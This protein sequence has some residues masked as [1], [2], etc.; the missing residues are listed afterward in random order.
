MSEVSEAPQPSTVEL[1][2]QLERL[3]TEAVLVRLKPRQVEAEDGS[4]YTIYTF[5]NKNGK[6]VEV[7]FYSPNELPLV[8]SEVKGKFA[9]I[10]GDDPR[11]RTNEEWEDFSLKII[12]ASANAESAQSNYAEQVKEVVTSGKGI[13]LVEAGPEFLLET[14]EELGVELSK[15]LQE[16]LSKLREKGLTDAGLEV[17]DSVL[18]GNLINDEEGFNTEHQHEGEALFLLSLMGDEK[19]QQLLNKKKGAL[20]KV[21]EKREAGEKARFAKLR[22]ENEKTGQEA[23][24]LKELVAVHATR[25]LP[26]RGA[27]Y[28]EILTTFEGSGWQIPRDT[29]HF[30]LNHEVA[31]HMY[32]SWEGVPYVVI[33]PLEKMIKVNGKPTVLNTVD[34]F[35]EVGPGK[36]LVL[37]ENTAMVRPGDLSEGEILRGVNSNEVLYKASKLKPEDI[38]TL[39]KELSKRARDRLNSNIVGIVVESFSECPYGDQIGLS[40]EQMKSLVEVTGF[41]ENRLNVLADLQERPVKEVVSNILKMAEV[42]VADEQKEMIEKKIRGGIA[43]VIKRVAVEKKIIQMGYEVQPGGMW[44]WG[45][46]WEV[47]AQ[48]VALGAK[49]EVPVMAHT[50]HISSRLENAAIRG[51]GVLLDVERTPDVKE[52]VEAFR[53]ARQYIR[54]E[55]I[56]KISQ[57]TRRMLYLTGVI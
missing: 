52:R 29:I 44:A 17:M 54:E 7:L 6:P 11:W 9:I 5:E 2:P 35:W 37:P 3:S 53:K 55:Y 24:E 33:S 12:K 15:L 57:D 26:Q 48:T 4:H 25:Y 38:A 21:D 14:A 56:P 41:H 10:N 49:L 8:E 13:L 23:L 22:E 43:A 28:L 30:A 36:R 19:A 42:G 51:L 31:P 18:A 50:N 40:E 16:A 1:Q 47:T 46:S 32:G 20:Q 27:D 45:D 34:T 39:F